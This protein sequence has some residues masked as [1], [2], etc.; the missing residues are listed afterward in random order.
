MFSNCVLCKFYRLRN[1]IVKSTHSDHALLNSC[2]SLA[3]DNSDNP[4]EHLVHCP[5]S[6]LLGCC[7]CNLPLRFQW[8]QTTQI[9]AAPHWIG[10][11]DGSGEQQLRNAWLWWRACGRPCVKIIVGFWLGW[12]I[13]AGLGAV[14]W[15]LLALG[16]AKSLE[17]LSDLGSAQM[18]DSLLDWDWE[19]MLVQ[20]WIFHRIWVRW[21]RRIQG[22]IWLG[23]G[24]WCRG[25]IF[26]RIWTR[27][28]SWSHC[29]VLR[30]RT[31]W[32]SDWSCCRI[33]AWRRSRCHCVRSCPRDL[34]HGFQD[35]VL[36][37][38]FSILSF[39][40]QWQHI[41]AKETHMK[42]RNRSVDPP[43]PHSIFYFCGTVSHFGPP[44]MI[45]VVRQTG[46]MNR[47]SLW[48]EKM[49]RDFYD[50]KK[51]I[52][53]SEWTEIWTGI[54]I[55][56]FMV[57]R[58]PTYECLPARL[59]SLIKRRPTKLAFGVKITVIQRSLQWALMS[60]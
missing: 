15:G 9:L 14:G 49:N 54:F 51:M 44:H 43:A 25:W 8:W 20:S 5:G 21:R 4:D 12:V 42:C 24:R 27:R 58:R 35:A 22:W 6:R 1:V 41:G 53:D 2:P 19:E 11:F 36:Y 39:K 57:A 33:W 47:D 50:P 60:V 7:D 26:C 45:K 3:D 38:G 40:T 56:H 34:L 23:R 48:T 37:S 29:W 31:C 17:V 52:R 13:V 16:W 10:A 59:P 18:L 30:W 32:G 46:Q 55:E 28:R